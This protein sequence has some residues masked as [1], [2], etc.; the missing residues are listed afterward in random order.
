MRTSDF[1]RI[2]V[3]IAAAFT[4]TATSALDGQPASGGQT[5]LTPFQAFRSGNELLKS[6]GD[7]KRAME[8]LNYAA[9]RGYPLAQ[10]KLGRIYAEG[11]GVKRDDVKAFH[12]FSRIASDHAES[13]PYT[14]QARFVASAYVSL[15]G[16]YLTGIPNSQ[17]RADPVRAR[18][19]VHYAASYFGDADAQYQLA[20]FYLEGIGGPKDTRQ[21]L[22][23]L[24]L[25]AQKGQYEAQA[26][27][28][29][30]LFHG[31]DGVPRQAGRGLMWLQLARDAAA[32]K[33]DGWIVKA[34]EECFASATEDERSIAHIHLEKF[35]KSAR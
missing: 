35:A 33:D 14:Q 9:E 17:V 34:Y 16:Y 24:G 5:S 11:D 7:R 22:R 13:S 12:Y 23:W 27:L 2:G 29:K 20:R 10:W 28:G 21:G 32:G 30:M 4:A 18:E 1:L 19:L 25:S 3:V 15:G 26:V 31:G 6:G 8:E